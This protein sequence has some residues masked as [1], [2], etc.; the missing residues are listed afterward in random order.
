M[1]RRA[2]TVQLSPQVMKQFT[3]ITII[4][5]ALLAMFSNGENSQLVEAVKAR[6][7]RNTLLKAEAAK[8]GTRSIRRDAVAENQ[9]SGEGYEKLN[10]KPDVGNPGSAPQWTPS[11]VAAGPDQAEMQRAIARAS[12][13]GPAKLPLNLL[14]ARSKAF[15]LTKEQIEELK[16]LARMRA[17]PNANQAD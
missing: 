12:A 7:A 3:L 1:R 6:E 15:K 4:A 17:D 11:S 16:R 2:P 5:T 10:D 9:D 8:V 13:P 14:K